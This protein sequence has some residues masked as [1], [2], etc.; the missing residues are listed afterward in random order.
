MEVRADK[1]APREIARVKNAVFKIAAVKH[2]MFE[3]HVLECNFARVKAGEVLKFECNGLVRN[4]FGDVVVSNSLSVAKRIISRNRRQVIVC[5][6]GFR[7]WVG[8]YSLKACL[9][10][11]GYDREVKCAYY[12]LFRGDVARIFA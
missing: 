12:P 10:I 1:S 5:H 2:A 9:L 6:F 4:A 11:S 8:S 3:R 7:N